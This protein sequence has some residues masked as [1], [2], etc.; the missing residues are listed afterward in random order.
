MRVY[1]GI[2]G[3]QDSRCFQVGVTVFRGPLSF[4]G[5]VFPLFKFSPG[6]TSFRGRPV[7]SRTAESTIFPLFQRR[8]PKKV[9]AGSPHWQGTGRFSSRPAPPRPQAQAA[10][11]RRCPALPRRPARPAGAS[12]HRHGDP[13]GN[14]GNLSGNLWPF[15][16]SCEREPTCSGWDSQRRQVSLLKRQGRGGSLS[17]RVLRDTVTTGDRTG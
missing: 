5:A 17:L 2:S 4:C 13:T 9:A 15:K 10:P 6:L 3:C 16:L 8:D 11:P 12:A 1:V 14:P 7:H